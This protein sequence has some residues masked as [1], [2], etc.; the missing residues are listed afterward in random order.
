M[1]FKCPLFLKM[2]WQI[3]FCF[4]HVMTEPFEPSPFMPAVSEAFGNDFEVLAGR[5]QRA[6]TDGDALAA[7]PTSMKENSARENN[8]AKIKV[9]V[10]GFLPS[11]LI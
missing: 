2:L 6:Q 1:H 11:L 9:V 3:L 4:Q 8:V 10:C 5:Q 7:L